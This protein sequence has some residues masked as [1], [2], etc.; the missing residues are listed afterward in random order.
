MKCT[1]KLL[2]TLENAN[3]I[4]IYEHNL[5]VDDQ[6]QSTGKN[7]TKIL[8]FGTI[9]GLINLSKCSTW[10]LDSNYSLV[11]KLFLQLYV[12]RVEINGMFISVMYCE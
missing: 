6:I 10:Y 4:P 12:I 8:I 1:S 2:T 7:I 11:H 5:P 9:D 3:P